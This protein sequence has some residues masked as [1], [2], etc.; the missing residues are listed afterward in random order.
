MS[1]P[2]CKL[3]WVSLGALTACATLRSSSDSSLEPSSLSKV[4][5]LLHQPVQIT[6][7][8]DANLAP[9]LSGDGRYLVYTTSIN[10]NKEVVLRDRKKG[11][12]TRLTWHP[13]DDFAP[14]VSPDASK[15]AFLSRRQDA[16]GDI[17]IVPTGGFA[18][19]L[20]TERNVQI[21][22]RPESEELSPAWWP[23]SE[24]VLVPT[25][26]PRNKVPKLRVLNTD[27]FVWADWA[28]ARGEFPQISNDGK[29]VVY[30][31]EGRILSNS[32]NGASEKIIRGIGGGIWSRPRFVSGKS[33]VIAVRYHHDTN[34][35]GRIDGS[36]AGTVWKLTCNAQFDTV[37]KV[38]QL[39]SA[40]H[41][42]FIPE[43][44]A[45]GLFVTLQA[46]GALEI[47]K[48]PAEGQGRKEWAALPENRWL[49]RMSGLYD[50]VFALN[51]VAAELDAQDKK[52]E[53][54]LFRIRALRELSRRSIAPD[55]ALAGQ[56]I[57]ALYPGDASV[58]RVVRATAIAAEVRDDLR[59]IQSNQAGK[60]NRT[61][62]QRA[63][64][65]LDKLQD[66][67]ENK[68]ASS[69]II[70]DSDVSA[71]LAVTKA[72]L[73]HE[74]KDTAGAKKALVSVPINAQA[75]FKDEAKLVTADILESEA[76]GSLAREE[77]L[78]N[79]LKERKASSDLLRVA[80]N[81]FMKSIEDR[82]L[83]NEEI[84]QIRQQTAAL[85]LIPPLLHEL[86]AKRFVKDRK[87]KI[88]AQEYR[89]ILEDH[90]QQNPE[91]T[92]EL[93]KV[94]V[95]IA[96]SQG[97]AAEIDPALGQLSKCVD[98][99]AVERVE[100]SVIRAE[101]LVR[102]GLV[103]L[104]EREF[105][106]ALKVFKQATEIDPENLGGWRGFLDASFQRKTLKEELKRLEQAYSKNRRSPSITYAYGYALTYEI[107]LASG[108]SAK[109]AAINQS[110]EIIERAKDLS[111]SSIF[112]YQTLGW[113]HM[114]K[115]HWIKRFR[116][117]GGVLGKTS[118]LKAQVLEMFGRPEEDQIELGVDSFLAAIYLADEGSTERANLLQNLGEAYH[119][120]ENH[121][122]A[123]LHLGERIKVSSVQ[124]F[125][126]RNAEA[127]VYRLAGR[128][129]FQI[130]ELDL[131]ESIQ[132]KGLELWMAGGNDQQISFSMDALA[133]TL[134]ERKKFP[135][136]IEVYN[137]LRVR[138]L[139]AK[140]PM[141][142]NRT[143]SNIAYCQYMNGDLEA[144]LAS[145]QES[146]KGFA[147]GLDQAVTAEK[148]NAIAVDVG[149]QA[150]A[151]KGFDSS[152]LRKMN[153]TF[154]ARIQEDLGR[155][156]ESSELYRAKI[157]LLEELEEKAEGGAKA[158][159]LEEKVIT[160]N[161]L[162]F[163]LARSGRLSEAKLELK[164][165]SGEAKLLRS[166]ALFSIDETVN[167]A[168][169]ARLELRLAALGVATGD[170]LKE[171]SERLDAID[172]AILKESE[173]PASKSKW[174]HIAAKI[175]IIRVNLAFLKE[176]SK[177]RRL[178]VSQEVLK[179]ADTISD[180]ALGSGSRRAEYA[181]VAFELGHQPAE[182]SLKNAMRIFRRKA[183]A[184]DSES[185][186]YFAVSDDAESALGSLERSVAQGSVVANIYD[187]QRLYGSVRS[188]VK[189]SPDVRSKVTT[190]RRLG[191]VMAQS[192]LN[193]TVAK[194]IEGKTTPSETEEKKVKPT[195]WRL[196]RTTDEQALQNTLNVRDAFIG[197]V[198]YQGSFDFATYQNG[199]WSVGESRTADD[200]S[201][202]ISEDVDRLY[203][204]CY[205]PRC[206]KLH[207]MLSRA[208]RRVSIV[209]SIEQLPELLKIRRIAKS[210]VV[211]VGE[212]ISK[213]EAVTKAG[214]ESHGQD[215]T[216]LEGDRWADVSRMAGGSHVWVMKPPLLV[217]HEEPWNAEFRLTNSNH[218]PLKAASAVPPWYNTAFVIPSVNAV[219]QNVDPMDVYSYLS[220]WLLMKNIPMGIVAE[221]TTPRTSTNPE[222]P[223]PSGKITEDL[224]KILNGATAESIEGYV[225]IG[226]PGLLESEAM[227]FARTHIGPAK[228][229][230][231]DAQ[232]DGDF[233]GARRYYLEV[234]HYADLLKN[235]DE[236]LSTLEA[237]VKALFQ[238]REYHSALH[239]QRRRVDLL[240]KANADEE[241]LA[242]VQMETGILATRAGLGSVAR[243]YLAE[244]EV[245]YVKDQDDL[246][247]PQIKHYVAL[248]YE[249][250]G[251]YE[252]TVESYEQARR[253][254][255]K[256][257]SKAEAAQKYL[258]I[259]NIYKERLSNLPVA[260]DFY[261]KAYQA[262]ENAGLNDRLV[263]VQIDRAN[264]LMSLGETKWAINVIENRVLN[265]IDPEKNLLLWIRAAQIVANAY[266]RAGMFQESQEYISKIKRHIPKLKD[267][268]AQANA[269]ID[270][271]NLYAMNLEKLGNHQ[272]ATK[273]FDSILRLSQKFK[274][275][276][277]EAMV[278]NNIGF[279]AREAGEVS[280]SL[281]YFEKA[282]AIDK[283]LKSEADQAYDLRNMAMS[284]TL[285]GNLIQATSAAEEALAM[286]SRLKLAH[287]EAYSLFALAEIHL[288]KGKPDDALAIFVKAKDVAEKAYL[289][290]FVWRAHAAAGAIQSTQGRLNDAATSYMAAVKIIESL[291]A[292]L[293]SQSSRT[294]FASDRGVQDV[295]SGGVLVYMKLGMIEE[296]WKLS[297]RGRARAFIDSLGSRAQSFGDP[298]LDI[299]MDEVIKLRS[300]VEVLERR[301]TMLPL[302]SPDLARAQQDLVS[303]IQ[304]RNART[305]EMVRKWPR[306]EP[307]IGVKQLDL[308]LVTGKLDPSTAL[309]EYM[310][311]G[312]ETAFWVIQDG[313]ISGGLI[314]VS[315]QQLSSLVDQYR[316]LMQ[317]FAAVRGTGRDLSTILLDAPL[318]YL[319]SA[320]ELIIVPHS[321]LHYVPFASLPVGDQ[322]LLDLFP[323]SYLE[324]A[325]MLRF[326]PV[327]K[328]AL[329]NQ[330]R[331]VAFGNPDRGPDLNLPFAE[332]EVRAI[333]RN[334]PSTKVVFAKEATKERFVSLVD[335]ADIVHF[336]GHGE[337]VEKDPAAS[338]LLFADTGDLTVQDIFELKMPAALVTLSA[339]ETGLGK[340]SSGDEMVGF[341]RALFFAGAESIV[342]SLW[343]VSDVASAVTIKRFYASLSEG[344]PRAAALRDAQVLVR[345][346]YNHPAYWS[347]FKLSGESK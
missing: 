286:S 209:A 340:L 298:S 175:R 106:V 335:K 123:L 142:L 122:K 268:T 14:V 316:E 78:V 309:L 272:E 248:S 74:S 305:A 254:Y 213:D 210:S 287:N 64:A 205:G 258:D 61:R 170:S 202:E 345:K 280:Q 181:S 310:C 257:G 19:G 59:A 39:T 55:V 207:S 304:L 255:E 249:S 17:A 49:E 314:D 224:K 86:V 284:W 40:T 336:A 229:N 36:D 20:L 179:S 195:P 45:D 139:A 233:Q 197:A 220:V 172:Q 259:G 16:A 331:L 199:Q 53:A 99:L 344:R 264:T 176:D 68:T 234:L 334:F 26:D 321:E 51:V 15:V 76:G 241:S 217:G 315:R 82:D 306:V 9:D 270:A 117:D 311:L 101:A 173:N 164:V 301:V 147:A 261:D 25:R 253:L 204:S 70:P 148:R 130:D 165:A 274:L 324:S 278:L 201:P 34:R 97:Q 71:I 159:V 3:L 290:D 118:S 115:G 227:D 154:M 135:E 215:A 138:H 333:A 279:W 72:S 212:R 131:A 317:N 246:K 85:P 30:V 24:S 256:S 185:W 198:D 1:F 312:E 276:G 308:S 47:F 95:D 285:L 192:Y 294:G 180:S 90:C 297:E 10:G 251:D 140:R 216:F 57:E 271:D 160:R 124:P 105:G 54:V 174:D 157:R 235:K 77:A 273:L 318:R 35:D 307:L 190:I 161:N 7:G 295:Y 42:A 232:D 136:A 293:A 260:L 323:I 11:K 152:G 67:V 252:K 110:L 182:G 104:R 27:S 33:E 44:R 247:L 189:S 94:Y 292:G 265:K 240:K 83:G 62:V 32:A 183:L 75:R 203:L 238:G 289:Q 79:F 8:N 329:N 6:V 166:A 299:S 267:P 87:E 81:R 163:A 109:I 250:D 219:D 73:M 102:R 347:A 141:E 56:D 262:F 46:K 50:R 313:K 319:N 100:A 302:G 149:G 237:L 196:L 225:R 218:W 29:N 169:W 145:F 12:Q 300:D 4:R 126:D 320:K 48:F 245:F 282:L 65:E 322:F 211:V 129:A 52:S 120:L 188:I 242:A 98:S 143:I 128:S 111:P 222:V 121:Q 266:Y 337:F 243:R 296:G 38:E 84:S 96:L 338:R 89:Q 167:L 13:A 291:R 150:S 41:N 155:F 178:E 325:E 158:A 206:K 194:P 151:A 125:S 146:E 92:I 18:A 221:M 244:A 326:S 127:S 43:L 88:A 116:S 144:A 332:R 37:V 236:Y 156:S 342:S 208:G 214:L 223:S 58:S 63:I 132:R 191:L 339:C 341:N 200:I 171:V 28:D 346:Y 112:P 91:V 228:E 281:S 21:A 119:Q 107:D 66:D 31:R 2:R 277:K 93:A 22:S 288:K 177:E 134:R 275:R 153:L 230:A 168:A 162:G 184:K 108:A 269:T 239:F 187:R 327:D 328:R 103:L 283:D 303:K 80:A 69:E 113:L 226:D 330:S 60:G 133:L 231:L 5:P 343:R 186:R 114:Q 193:A 263:S 23:D 137:D